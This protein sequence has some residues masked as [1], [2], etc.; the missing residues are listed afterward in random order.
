[1]HVE[2]PEPPAAGA[3]RAAAPRASARGVPWKY[4]IGMEPALD[5]LQHRRTPD[6]GVVGVASAGSRR[7][8][9]RQRVLNAAG[10]GSWNSCRP[11]ISTRCCVR[12]CTSPRVRA[13][14][15][16]IPGECPFPL[17][18]ELPRTLKDATR[19]LAACPQPGGKALIARRGWPARSSGRPDPRRWSPRAGGPR[20]AGGTRWRCRASPTSPICCPGCT[21]APSGTVTRRMC[22][23]HVVS[24]PG[25]LCTW[26]SHGPAQ[27]WSVSDVHG[28]AVRGEDRVPQATDRS[29]PVCQLDQCDPESP[30]LRWSTYPEPRGQRVHHRPAGRQRRAVDRGADDPVAEFGQQPSG[31]GLVVGVR[32]RGTP[33]A[34]PPG[35]RPSPAATASSGI[36]DS[37]A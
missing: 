17:V 34:A 9:R 7:P 11:A 6:D 29:V 2:N 27:D 30:K 25:A 16:A 8:M 26:T 14:P 10:W 23:Y 19:A 5:E 21:V 32:R 3:M 24:A 4:G 28:P 20:S 33:S 22:A 37:A 1:M 36:R 12:S 35:R 15:E 31:E 13:G 18:W